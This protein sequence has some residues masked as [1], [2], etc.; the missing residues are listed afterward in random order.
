MSFIKDKNRRKLEAFEW[1]QSWTPFLVY[2]VSLYL[3]ILAIEVKKE[4]KK[5]KK[6]KKDIC[7]LLLIQFVPTTVLLGSNFWTL[8]L[9]DFVILWF[10]S[11]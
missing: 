11:T 1:E 2:H 7:Y 6:K 3:S 10:L 5:K 9:S 4:K 8:Y